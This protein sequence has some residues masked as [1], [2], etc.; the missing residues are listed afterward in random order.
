MSQRSSASGGRAKPRLVTGVVVSDKMDKT[1]TVREER[2]IKHP[3][4]GKYIRRAT[5][6]KAHDEKNEAGEGDVVEIRLTRPLCK[7]KC[8]TLVRLVRRARLSGAVVTGASEVAGADGIE[9]AAAP[10]D[11]ETAS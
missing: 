10:E 5:T 2:M 6:Y 7:T 4:Y 11:E 1:I 9:S 3:L 8:W